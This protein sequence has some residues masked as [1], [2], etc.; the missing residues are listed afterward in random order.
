MFTR[1]LAIK[2]LAPTVLVSIALVLACIFG[3]LALNYVNTNLL[4]EL[5]ENIESTR[6]AQHL[7]TATEEL[8]RLLKGAHDRPE[9]LARQINAKNQEARQRLDEALALA[10]LEGEKILVPKI[11]KGFAE[12]IRDWEA[13]PSAGG[14][15]LAD[16]D[17]NLAGRLDDQVL[18]PCKDLRDFNLK[19]I[20]TSN[21]K[22][23]QIIKG[24]NWALL[25]VGLAAPLSGLLLGYAVARSLHHSIYQLSVGIRDAAGRLNR[26]LGSVTLEEQGDLPDLHRQLQGVIAEIERVVEQLQQREREVLRAEQLAAVGQIAAGVAH[27]LRNP[28]TSVK[29]LVQTGLE[30]T[31]GLP[32]DDLRI[33][34][35]EIR[36]MEQCIQL[37]IDFARPPRSERRQADLL[38]VLRRALA[39][40]EGPARRQ[41]ITLVADLPAEP[42]MLMIDPEQIHQVVVNLLL[43]AL[44]AL[45]RGGTVQLR[46]LHKPQAS[47]VSP[48]SVSEA[49]EVQVRDDGPGIAPR[50]RDRLFEPFVSSKETGLGLGL[51][52]CKRLIE[53]HG[54]T[55]KGE[56]APEGGAVFAFT[57]PA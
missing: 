20:E 53:G 40:V 45:P 13:R 2:L 32:A 19:E 57:L 4:K 36:R 28:M 46:V 49:I 34:E 26:E 54:G 56:D 21:L 38:T 55:I 33:I 52:I 8:I 37:F 12:Y 44:D 31:T 51:S 18:R 9:E 24:L 30:G 42:V 25:A 3:A 1:P 10:N 35:H 15:E 47:A 16:Y 27:E 11:E 22:N 23:Q 14:S 17:K 48:A 6:A 43:N 39:L 5:T 29:M 7:E 41:K 50:V